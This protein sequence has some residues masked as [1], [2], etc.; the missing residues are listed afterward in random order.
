MSAVR[1]YL[2]G[3]EWILETSRSQARSLF[4]RHRDQAAE[5]RHGGDWN[6][7]EEGLALGGFPEPL[8]E[9][10]PHDFAC[11]L[12]VDTQEPTVSYRPHLPAS[13]QVA[14]HGF[15]DGNRRI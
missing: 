9:I 2:K 3:N 15:R 6:L 10:L 8:A 13:I 14:H 12:N 11:F 7:I 1:D 4:E 5:P